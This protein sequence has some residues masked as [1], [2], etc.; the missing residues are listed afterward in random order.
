MN[1]LLNEIATKVFNAFKAYS[2]L[3]KQSKSENKPLHFN[4]LL[5]GSTKMHCEFLP[6]KTWQWFISVN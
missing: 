3:N 6:S 5:I 1:T 4:S 2:A